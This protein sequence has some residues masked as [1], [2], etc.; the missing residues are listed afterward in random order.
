MTAH[1]PS[2]SRKG[3]VSWGRRLSKLL[4]I[5]A[6][7]FVL[8]PRE[9]ESVQKKDEKPGPFPEFP[10]LPDEPE[11]GGGA[12]SMS[13]GSATWDGTSPPPF[14]EVSGHTGGFSTRIP[15]DV[16]SFRGLEPALALVYGSSGGSGF[17]GV[18]WSVSGFSD[19]E[20]RSGSGGWPKFD[21]TDT[22]WVDGQK[23][24]PCGASAS[25]GCDSGGTHFTESENYLRIVQVGTDS[26]TVTSRNGVES[27]Y[28]VMGFTGTRKF[29]WGLTSRTDTL[30]NQVTYTWACT[31]ETD[32]CYPATVAY[33]G[34]LVTLYRE[35]RPDPVS[36]PAHVIQ[37]QRL[38]TVDVTLS[39]QRVRAYK[40]LYSSSASTERSLLSSVTVYGTN[41]VVNGSGTITS[42]SSLPPTSFTY[43]TDAQFASF[44]DGSL[45]NEEWCHEGSP[46]TFL[47]TGNFN[48]DGKEDI[49]CHYGPA[50]G[51][52][53][54]VR[55]SNAVNS[56]LCHVW[57]LW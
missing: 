55:L 7:F 38:K 27:I 20:R 53:T 33:N 35:T 23:L 51:N 10:D 49:F 26:W 42:G 28:S 11:G 29:R 57:V 14:V 43:R 44:T 3:S 2:F 21:S 40:L 9:G 36:G 34:A 37:Y 22:Y 30:G 12:A 56:D 54:Y 15:I 39:G 8:A 52:H 32:Y 13:S 50:N 24:V 31:S 47:G 45:W 5:L 17:A 18:G 25:P 48:G 4:T 41:A 19:V 16:P 1:R 6:L 46:G